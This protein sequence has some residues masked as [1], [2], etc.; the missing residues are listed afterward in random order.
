MTTPVL[1]RIDGRLTAC[2]TAN[3][4]SMKICAELPPLDCR[5]GSRDLSRNHALAKALGKSRTVIDAT[6]GLGQ[7]AMFMACLGYQVTAIE[8]SEILIK[9]VRDLLDNLDADNPCSRAVSE[10]LRLIQGD[11][12]DLLPQCEHPDVVYPDVIYMDP[13]FPP[14]RRSSALPR[15][16]IQLIR[17]VVG[18]DPDSEKLFHAALTSAGK[19]LVV[20]R[21]H[22]APPLAENAHHCIKSK[23]L[24][25][26][27]YL[28]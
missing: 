6:A 13:M 8:R 10:R 7:D 19:R 3:N 28:K 12:I 1:Q 18:D 22:Y 5:P 9:L 24:R 21:P 20:K 17:A 2:L 16:E 14:K 23:L 15:K 27:V 25:Y 4:E 26:D 11:A